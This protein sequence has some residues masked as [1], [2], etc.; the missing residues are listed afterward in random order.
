MAKKKKNADRQR[1]KRAQARRERSKKKR[2][3]PTPG[4]P[5]TYDAWE[6]E[7]FGDPWEEDAHVPC[8]PLTSLEVPAPERCL[9]AAYFD[10]SGKQLPPPREVLGLAEGPLDELTVR[11]AWKRTLIENPPERDPEAARRAGE[12][13]D[14]LLDPEQG[15]ARIMGTLRVPD[16]KA[17]DLDASTGEGTRLDP[18]TRLAGEVAIYA[19]VEDALLAEG[20]GSPLAGR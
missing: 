1:L 9:P 12:A 3:A 14:L 15:V 16:P 17:W 8:F 6:D 5:S 2:A 4:G 19:L 20:L 10:G 11:E 7:L 13:R 18:A